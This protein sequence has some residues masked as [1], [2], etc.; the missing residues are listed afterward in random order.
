MT[1]LS[2]VL[3]PSETFRRPYSLNRHEHSMNKRSPERIWRTAAPKWTI[4]QG[5][6]CRQNINLRNQKQAN[7]D[8]EKLIGCDLFH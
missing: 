3:T 5:F 1:N 2:T 8:F 6:M 7:N 4:T